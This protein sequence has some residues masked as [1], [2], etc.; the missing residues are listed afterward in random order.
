VTV[1]RD[2]TKTPRRR[3]LRLLLPLAGIAAVVLTGCASNAPNDP[4]DPAGPA[5]RDIYN[6]SKPVFI[7][8]GVVFVLVEG[9]IVFVVLKF[10]RRPDDDEVPAQTHGNTRLE[11]GWTILPAVILA[12]ITVP[13]VVTLFDLFE[14]PTDALEVSVTGQQWW[15]A[16]EYD[17]YTVEGTDTPVITANELHIPAGRPIYLTLRSKDVIHSFWSPRLNGKRDV[18]PGRVH[19]WTI[20]ADKPGRYAGQCT[21]FCG[22]SHANMLLTVVAH[23]EAGWE[24]WIDGQQ[25]AQEPLVEGTD[26]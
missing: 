10:R 15:W 6:L 20:E 1:E 21:E 22:A 19:N 23:D 18:V 9:L 5:A 17:D 12:V 4:M 7:I 13:T 25:E 11:I 24:K 16:Y 26:T 2:V 14:K 3:L 8:A